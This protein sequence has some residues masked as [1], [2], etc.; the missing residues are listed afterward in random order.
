M[1]NS[2]P[3]T[4]CAVA[5][6]LLLFWTVGQW[7]LGVSHELSS[8]ARALGSWV[9]IPLKEWMSVCVYSVFVLSCVYV[10]SLRRADHSSKESCRLCKKDYGTEEEARAQQRTVEPLMN[11][12]MNE[13][14]MNSGMSRNLCSSKF[15]A[16]L[17]FSVIFML[18]VSSYLGWYPYLANKCFKLLP[19]QMFVYLHRQQSINSSS[20]NVLYSRSYRVRQACLSS[21][22]TLYFK[23]VV[24]VVKKS[25]FITWSRIVYSYQSNL[26]QD[27]VM[28]KQDFDN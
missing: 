5:P 18:A 20:L 6:N 1:W 28:Y 22:M 19:Y 14:W 10:A 23:W 3:R 12:R 17:S 21:N 4:R 7:L 25:I 15:Y 24:L 27:L 13:W 16:I 8:L 26:A 11:E 9:R 2:H